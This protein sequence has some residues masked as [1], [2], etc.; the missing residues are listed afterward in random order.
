MNKNSWYHSH[1]FK[2]RGL[3]WEFTYIYFARLQLAFFTQGQ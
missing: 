2:F 3:I 1:S